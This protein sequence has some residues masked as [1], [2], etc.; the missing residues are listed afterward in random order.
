MGPEV[1]AGAQIPQTLI[2]WL[3]ERYRI[4]GELVPNRDEIEERLQ[5]AAQVGEQ[6]LTNGAAQ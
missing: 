2:P 5:L 6:Q 4:S 3:A 1:A